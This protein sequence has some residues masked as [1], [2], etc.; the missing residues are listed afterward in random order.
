MALQA[1]L[2]CRTWVKKQLKEMNYVVA[3]LI[4]EDDDDDEAAA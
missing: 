4:I 2:L 1:Q 3:H